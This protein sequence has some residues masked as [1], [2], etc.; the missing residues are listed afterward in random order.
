VENIYFWQK[1]NDIHS[2]RWI[3]SFNTAKN[4]ND[5]SANKPTTSKLIVYN[6]IMHTKIYD[7]IKVTGIPIPP[8]LQRWCPNLWLNDWSFNMNQMNTVTRREIKQCHKGRRTTHHHIQMA[9]S[10]RKILN[11]CEN[12]LFKL[13]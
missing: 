12:R 3:T 10:R 9:K 7:K 13:K 6:D 1:Q 8:D 5:E 4:V 2:N 11:L